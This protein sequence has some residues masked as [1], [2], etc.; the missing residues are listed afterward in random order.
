MKKLPIYLAVITLLAVLCITREGS[1]A[2]DITKGLGGAVDTLKSTN[3]A[4]WMPTTSDKVDRLANAIYWAE[5]GAKTN[6]PFGIK[7]IKCEG[8]YECRRICENTISNNIRRYQRHKRMGLVEKSYRV[9]ENPRTTY[10]EFLQSR[11]C[12]TSGNLSASEK[13]L[14]GHWLKNVI[15]FLENR[16]DG[17]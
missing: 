10:L 6:F 17:E 5:G 14:N 3:W 4:E 12:P 16:G 2:N 15:W 8:Y 9:S 11:Y 1:V 7:S 13:A